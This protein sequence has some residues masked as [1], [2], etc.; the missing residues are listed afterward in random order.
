MGL[1][2]QLGTMFV[3]KLLVGVCKEI[4]QPYL[5]WRR[6]KEGERNSDVVNGGS[7]VESPEDEKTAGRAIFPVEEQFLLEEY[8]VMKGTFE[9][10]LEMIM[11]YGFATLFVAA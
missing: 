11:Q 5:S 4:V 1:R 10:Y 7:E 6:K 3:S 2:I 8:H 9:D